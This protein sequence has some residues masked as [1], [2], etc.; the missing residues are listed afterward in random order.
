[1]RRTRR[2]VPLLLAGTLTVG[3][4]SGAEQVCDPMDPL[5]GT[6]GGAPV[7]TVVVTS[8]VD[9]VMAVG[10]T[11]TMTAVARDASASTVSVTFSWLS[12]NTTAATANPSTGA[13]TGQAA[14]ST[15]I[16]ASQGNNSVTGEIAM[17]V[18]PADLTA[19]ATLVNDAFAQALRAALS[20]TPS[21]S[22]GTLLTTCATANTA[23]HVRNLDSCL[24]SLIAVNP[25]NGND[26]AL[27]G[28]LDLFFAQARRQLQL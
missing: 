22:V 14:G 11:A 28:V 25:T 15:I 21:G 4:C 16:R 7:A 17:R 13:V 23:G 9:T 5:C 1:M 19:A 6:G 3:S 24:S 8:P 27:L 26:N 20:T 12:T 2:V 18:V 10:R